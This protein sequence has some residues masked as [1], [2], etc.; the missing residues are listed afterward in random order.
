MIEIDKWVQESM[1]LL[2]H[3][4]EYRYAINALR[5]E[6]IRAYI[7]EERLEELCLH[8]SRYNEH[9]LAVDRQLALLKDEYP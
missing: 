5:I 6:K 9:V 3:R 7:Y 1:L 4:L 8:Q 2:E